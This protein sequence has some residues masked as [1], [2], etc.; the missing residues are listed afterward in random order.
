MTESD[1]LRIVR[2]V[3]DQVE[4]SFDVD[5]ASANNIM[6]AKQHLHTTLVQRIVELLTKNPERLMSILYRIDVRESLVHEIFSKA[7]PP[8][9]PYLLADAII[10]RQMQ[11]VQSR[12]QR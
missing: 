12:E 11:K 4:R 3:A 6:D 8:E 1:E 9:V 10:E 7:L 5:V 2:N